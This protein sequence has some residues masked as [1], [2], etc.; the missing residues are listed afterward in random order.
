MLDE[1]IFVY[2]VPKPADG[3]VWWGFRASAETRAA[4]QSEADRLVGFRK[5]VIAKDHLRPIGRGLVK[6]SIGRVR[7][8][9]WLGAGIAVWLGMVGWKSG[10]STL[11]YATNVGHGHL[12]SFGLPMK[13]EGRAPN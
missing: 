12:A 4:A 9:P 10:A 11:M 5:I 6:S 7:S 13:A 3:M 1:A 2:D 8:S